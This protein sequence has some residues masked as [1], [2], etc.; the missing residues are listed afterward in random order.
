MKYRSL[1]IYTLLFFVVS[2]V[3]HPTLPVTSLTAYAALTT[4]C[5]CEGEEYRICAGAELTLSCGSIES[6]ADLCTRWS[7]ELYLTEDSDVSQLSITVIPEVSTTYT[8]YVTDE[9]GEIIRAI[10]FPVIVGEPFEASIDASSPVLCNGNDVTLKGMPEGGDYEYD[11]A[12][13]DAMP[14][15]HKR[16]IN[17]PANYMLTVT[18]TTTNC[19]DDVALELEDAENTPTEDA[20]RD[21]FRSK[22]FLEFE[23]TIIDED[24]LVQPD[25]PQFKSGNVQDEFGGAILFDAND[26]TPLDVAN[27]MS[28][29]LSLIAGSQ[30]YVTINESFCKPGAEANQTVIEEVNLDFAEQSFSY[31]VHLWENPEEGKDLFMVKA[32]TPTHPEPTPDSDLMGG[33]IK[34][35]VEEVSGES[36]MYNYTSKSYQEVDI[37][38]DQLADFYDQPFEKRISN[39]YENSN[40]ESVL[41]NEPIFGCEGYTT[42]IP[43]QLYYLNTAGKTISLPQ[44]AAPFYNHEVSVNY[45]HDLRA[46]TSFIAPPNANSTVPIKWNSWGKKRTKMHL[47]FKEAKNPKEPYQFPA[48]LKLSCSNLVP[49]IYIMGNTERE[50]NCFYFQLTGYPYQAADVGPLAS[51][52]RT[53]EAE[54]D[55]EAEGRFCTNPPVSE[56]S[57]AGQSCIPKLKESHFSEEDQ[58][59][60]FN[61]FGEGGILYKLEINSETSGKEYIYGRYEGNHT[62]PDEGMVYYWWNCPLGWTKVE[63]EEQLV[64]IR[65]DFNS[66]RD[67]YDLLFGGPSAREIGQQVVDNI[68]GHTAL[69]IA[70][71]V[72]IIGAPA[73]L[74]NA[75][76][77]LVE[78]E[79]G[80]A[81]FALIGAIPFIGDGITFFR[82]TAHATLQ[83][84]G[85]LHRPLAVFKYKCA[86]GLSFDSNLRTELL[87][88]SLIDLTRPSCL[89]SERE[90]QILIDNLSQKANTLGLADEPVNALSG[91][92]RNNF[93]LEDSWELSKLINSHDGLLINW[94]KTFGADSELSNSQRVELFEWILRNRNNSESGILE[95]FSDQTRRY[96]VHSWKILHGFPQNLRSIDN[97]KAIDAFETVQPESLDLIDDILIRIKRS[98]RQSYLNTLNHVANNNVLSQSLTRSRIATATEIENALNKI[99]DFRSGV[100]QGG[101]YGYLDGSVSGASIDNN[102]MW[103]SVSLEDARNEIHIFE[104][105]DA[106][107]TTGE[108]LRIT[109]SEYRMLNNLANDLGA[110]RGG[111][112]PLI[113]GRL[114]IISENPY[115]LSC[116]GVIQQFNEMFPNIELILVDGVK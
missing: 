2:L 54:P 27:A 23:I 79:Y 44:G 4:D 41:N 99:R 29:P 80:D 84:G 91:F 21:Y 62:G 75:L 100:P 32:Q 18:N 105:I 88:P 61:P 59:G 19:S 25:G 31:W 50:G 108:W 33:Y 109:D 116:Q 57:V 17:T 55:F 89:L 10:E 13:L 77:Y 3:A 35:L 58:T 49:P 42:G 112:Y 74:A 38:L 46:V 106:P 9:S 92:L 83:Y 6:C 47:G 14:E 7:P 101:N 95:A 12:D 48:T 104:A 36:E 56:G 11:W 20:M 71:F 81:T 102:R 69:D 98:R 87:A 34:D 30:G 73:D 53:G 52:P 111:V 8:F 37:V 110:E 72:P 97:V 93:S 94:S 76:W 15:P 90:F 63:V 115:C 70:S 16:T 40:L 22:G 85:K 82:E 1:L 24:G 86:A 43:G 26:D 67:V 113:S 78:G 66:L 45:T 96:M 64:I 103:R 60:A 5:T 107:G 65:P 39:E 68:S 114:K 28:S 51:G